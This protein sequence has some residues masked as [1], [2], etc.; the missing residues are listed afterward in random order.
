MALPIQ[1]PRNTA[2]PRAK[3]G[4]VTVAIT[5]ATA[6]ALG[7]RTRLSPSRSLTATTSQGLAIPGTCMPPSVLLPP[8]T[9]GTQGPTGA[10]KAPLFSLRRA[11]HTACC[12]H[13]ASLR[14]LHAPPHLPLRLASRTSLSSCPAPACK[15]CSL[16]TEPGPLVLLPQPHSASS[17]RQLCAW[18]RDDFHHMDW[19]AFLPSVLIKY[20]WILRPRPCFNKLAP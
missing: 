7:S 13:R 20:K 19:F 11:Q 5:L 9:L 14:V 17:D 10:C 8:G 4:G 12:A 6:A 16:K 2:V 1:H 15:S 18:T 3:D